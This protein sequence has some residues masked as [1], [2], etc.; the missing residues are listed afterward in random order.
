MWRR[1]SEVTE[2]CA[3]KDRCRSARPTV[4]TETRTKTTQMSHGATA[5]SVEAGVADSAESGA[6]LVLSASRSAAVCLFAVRF[7]KASSL[8]LNGA[9]AGRCTSSILGGGLSS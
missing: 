9:A 8:N 2:S 5:A 6:L 1:V 7:A 4:Q 3:S